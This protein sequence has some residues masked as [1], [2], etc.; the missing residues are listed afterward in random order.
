MRIQKEHTSA[1]IIDIQERLFPHIHDNQFLENN[2]NIL[3]KGLNI[4][5]VPIIVTEQ[6]RKGL[7]NT[8]KSVAENVESFQPIEKVSFSC[9][10][11]SRFLKELML[12]NSKYVIIAGIEAHVCIM[13]TVIDLLENGY[14]P[15]VIEDCISSRKVN[16]KRIAMD[17]MRNEGAIITTYESILLELCREAAND[18]FRAV[19]QLIK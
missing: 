5:K 9:C 6:Y 2:V 12:R 3:I 18:T 7:G 14:H 11:E 8:V 1:I 15:V 13:Q 19:S 17:R 10:G 4:L 16:D